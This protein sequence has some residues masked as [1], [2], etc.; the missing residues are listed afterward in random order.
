M[1]ANAR[2]WD[3]IEQACRTFFPPLHFHSCNNGDRK[4]KN[5]NVRRSIYTR[6][7]KVHC[8][9]IPAS[10][11]TSQAS[12]YLRVNLGVL[13]RDLGESLDTFGNVATL[14]A[15]EIGMHWKMADWSQIRY[16]WIRC[17]EFLG[18]DLPMWQRRRIWPR[19]LE[20]Q[21]WPVVEQWSLR[22][23]SI[24]SECSPW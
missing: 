13:G 14:K 1:S 10:L 6:C 7:S 8:H 3:A 19:K 18:D 12:A 4:D 20:L 21:V 15:A 23:D 24:A 9:H 2:Y 17:V 16:M 22:F 5:E 11:N